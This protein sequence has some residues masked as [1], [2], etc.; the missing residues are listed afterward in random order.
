MQNREAV[1]YEQKVDY[2]TI[3]E[4]ERICVVYSSGSLISEEDIQAIDVQDDK[5]AVVAEVPSRS[6][7]P[8]A[9]PSAKLSMCSS[10]DPPLPAPSSLQQRRTSVRVSLSPN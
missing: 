4:I 8:I 9:S 6:T 7:S 2:R 10:S 5:L 3:R 1:I